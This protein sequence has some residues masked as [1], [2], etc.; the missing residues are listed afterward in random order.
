M[1]KKP[2]PNKAHL[3]LTDYRPFSFQYGRGTY[4]GGIF[5]P[6]NRR[7]IAWL[8][9]ESILD[10]LKEESLFKRAD[11]EGHHSPANG[12]EIFVSPSH[13]GILDLLKERYQN[14][15]DKRKE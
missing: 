4:D 10:W 15:I 2:S 9:E 1:K 7:S 13:D 14:I 3:Y 8:I 6:D 11:I 12:V 5:R